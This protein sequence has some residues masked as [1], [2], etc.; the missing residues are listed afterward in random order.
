MATYTKGFKKKNS[1]QALLLTIVGIIGAV[2]LIVGAVFIYDLATD[3]GS[4][5]DFEHIEAYDSI[6][7]NVDDQNV[8]YQD[9]LVYFYSD[10]CSNCIEIKRDVL[11]LSEKINGEEKI[12]FFVNASTVKETVTGDKA[13][14][15]DDVNLSSIR[16]PM[17]ISVVNG[18]FLE[19]FTGT[20]NVLQVLEEVES[21][22]YTPFN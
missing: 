2:L 5:D 15:L 12:V 22:T 3:T 7:V 19:S 11:K 20:T 10:D 1:E 21:G 17:L 6:L 16:T 8:A 13:E 9:Y 18:E 4:Y 14:F